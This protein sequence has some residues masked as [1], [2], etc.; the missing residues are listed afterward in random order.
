MTF[1]NFRKN[2]E[3]DLFVGIDK[4]K[5]LNLAKSK[6]L[7]LNF[8]Y[9]E[10]ESRYDEISRFNSLLKDCV[11]LYG[12]EMNQIILILDGEYVDFR[13]ILNILNESNIE[14]LKEEM[15]HK[16]HSKIKTNKKLKKLIHGK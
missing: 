5:I 12:F 15:M 2:L 7:N 6:G 3:D 8:L 1:E 4:M 9:N 10:S 14:I 16:I 11:E 13:S